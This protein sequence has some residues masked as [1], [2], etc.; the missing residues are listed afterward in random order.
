[1]LASL[2]NLLH[3][4]T[5]IINHLLRSRASKRSGGKNKISGRNASAISSLTVLVVGA[6]LIIPLALL[7][8]GVQASNPAAGT[9]SPAGP[10]VTWD[11]MAADYANPVSAS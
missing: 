9:I 11:G 8:D 5:S 2:R 7:I 10:S 1:M 6:A 3:R 4:R